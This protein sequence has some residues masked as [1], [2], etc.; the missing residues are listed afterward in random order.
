MRQPA[1]FLPLAALAVTAWAALWSLMALSSPP[2][3]EVSERS[4]QRAP[5]RSA[6]QADSAE[7]ATAALEA[8]IRTRAA[9]ALRQRL[10]NGYRFEMTRLE[11]LTLGDSQARVRAWGLL[12][13]PG[14][15]PAMLRVDLW[16]DRAT[17]QVDSLQVEAFDERRADPVLTAWIARDPGALQA[18]R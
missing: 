6:V 10:G 11:S 8:A 18:A 1:S 15:A 3:P 17:Q 4:T 5:S 14:E 16:L 9:E 12:F 7:S 2:L 13:S